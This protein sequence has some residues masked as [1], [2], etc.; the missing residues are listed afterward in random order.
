MQRDRAAVLDGEVGQALAGIESIGLGKGPGGTGLQTARAGPAVVDGWLVVL[1]HEICDDLAEE[2]ER[3]QP[4][5]N[6]A[7]VLAP[8]AQTGPAGQLTLQDGCRVDVVAPL[9]SGIGG[10][11]H[12]APQLSQACLDNV[13]VVV[14]SGI[15]RQGRTEGIGRGGRGLVVGHTHGDDT[16]GALDQV[17]G[18]AS[19]VQV[20][21]E[22]LHLA[23]IPKL[24]PAGVEPRSFERISRGET[25]QGKSQVMGM[26][27]D[28]RRQHGRLS[29]HRCVA[30]QPRPSGCDYW[31]SS[32]RRRKTS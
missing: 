5:I 15:A 24:Q 12:S 4:G 21:L 22:I 16:A 26:L 29:R 23:S 19:A 3:S 31:N 20:A 30:R 17:P 6:Q 18:I 25:H 28:P 2:E 9:R 7:G 27:A 8:P 13:V 32:M 1:Q 10:L 11:D 14:S